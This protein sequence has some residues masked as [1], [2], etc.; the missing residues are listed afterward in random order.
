M[1][2]RAFRTLVEYDGT[3]FFGWQVQPGR[4]TV[5]GAIEEAI[6][7]LTGEAVRVTGA[8]R[9][10]AGVHA[11]GQAAS[12]ALA[13]ALPARVLERALNATLPPDVSLR[14][15]AEAPP[16]WNARYRALSRVYVYRIV[17]RRAPLRRRTAWAMWARLD[18]AA[19]R[20]ASARLP[21]E[22]DFSAFARPLAPG[23]SGVIR[24]DRVEWRE[25]GD[26]LVVEC[27]AERFLR[28]MVR[29]IVGTLLDVGRGRR[30]PS[31][32]DAVLA[33]RDRRLAGPA[34]P[35][36]GLCLAAVRYAPEEDWP[37]P[38]GR[39]A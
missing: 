16:G 32:L 39:S 35:A 36:R 38:P 14:A 17:R 19:I 2:A 28:G 10:D 21:G 22:R 30:R 13:T 9:T 20:E 37:A 23:K 4:R 1:D 33:S 3:D 27:E 29:T 12:F 5:Q 25:E 24:L 31:D 18:L 34:V 15:L 6:E 8:G 7:R 26:L 11:A